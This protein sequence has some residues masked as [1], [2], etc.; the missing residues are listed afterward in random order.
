[1]Q[2]TL[3]AI[4]IVL[5]S[6]VLFPTVSEAKVYDYFQVAVLTVGSNNVLV[7]DDYTGTIDAAPYIKDGRTLVPLRFME[8]A[9]GAGVAW[10][11][12]SQVATLWFKGQ[13]LKVTINKK[14]A[15]VNG[16][17]VSLDVPAEI[18]ANRTFVPVSYTHLTLPT[19]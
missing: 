13:Q 16:K 14:E 5:A 9:L 4:C 10:D 7:N 17:T 1:M 11:Q 18:T 2:R 8:Q 3:F 15:T 12:S 6:F 19:N